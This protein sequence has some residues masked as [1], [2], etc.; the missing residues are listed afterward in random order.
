MHLVP[1][2][3]SSRRIIDEERVCDAIAA[4][5]EPDALQTWASRFALLG[6]PT[7]LGLLLC[8]HR[9]GPISVSDLAVA[10]GANDTTVSQALRLLRNAGAGPPRRDGRIVRYRLADPTLKSLLNDVNPAA[11]AS[12]TAH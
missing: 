8:I 4:L 2:G 7:R 1:A 6:N 11:P 12:H 3:R 10:V 5:G 9:V